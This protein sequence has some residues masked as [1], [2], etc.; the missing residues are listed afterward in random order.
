L[1]WR[2]ERDCS[3]L[4]RSSLADRSG[5][6]APWRADVLRR[7]CRGGSSNPIVHVR[8]F[9]SHRDNLRRLAISGWNPLKKLGG[10]RGIRTDSVALSDQQ[11]TD[12]ENN[13]VPITPT[14][15]HSCHWSRHWIS[16]SRTSDAR[17]IADLGPSHRME[18]AFHSLNA[19][20][21]CRCR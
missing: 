17:A 3:R 13:S 11:V 16:H 18:P 9:E 12:S 5:P 19:F 6:S 7:R 14:R 2:R 15:P 1:I 8:G 4:R 21:G 20:G 10:E